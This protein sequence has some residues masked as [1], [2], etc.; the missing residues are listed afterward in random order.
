MEAGA[1]SNAVPTEDDFEDESPVDNPADLLAAALNSL[2]EVTSDDLEAVDSALDA[3]MLQE[4]GTGIS[5]GKALLSIEEAE[6]KL[7]PE[8]LKILREKFKG[9]LTQTRH[10]DDKD[11]I[12]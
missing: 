9:S 5:S 6:A 10:L 1:L 7:S 12:F 4:S 2:D 8:I 3:M 11:Q